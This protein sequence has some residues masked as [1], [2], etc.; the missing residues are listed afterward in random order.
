MLAPPSNYAHPRELPG[1]SLVRLSGSA[2]C[3]VGGEVHPVG[4]P[5]T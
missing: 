5:P 1:N 4:A 2:T 3:T